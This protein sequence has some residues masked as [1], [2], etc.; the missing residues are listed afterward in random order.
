MIF[1]RDDAWLA[2]ESCINQKR[3]DREINAAVCV[4]ERVVALVIASQ[5]LVRVPWEYVIQS[6]VGF[7][8]LNCV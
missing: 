4:L 1:S 5:V 6:Q 8:R 7:S 3:N 2:S